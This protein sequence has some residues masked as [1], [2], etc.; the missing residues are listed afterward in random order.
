MARWLDGEMA[1]NGIRW[2]TSTVESGIGLV[3][4]VGVA[5]PV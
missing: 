2:W 1:R 5:G 4:R 3:V